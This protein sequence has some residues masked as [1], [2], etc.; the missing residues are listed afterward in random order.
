MRSPSGRGIPKYQLQ[1]KERLAIP[2]IMSWCFYSIFNH[3]LTTQFSSS[4]IPNQSHHTQNHHRNSESNGHHCNSRIFAHNI[5]TSKINNI[6]HLLSIQLFW[7]NSTI[8]PKLELLGKMNFLRGSVS[9]TFSPTNLRTGKFPQ[10]CAWGSRSH[11][12]NCAQVEP[13]PHTASWNTRWAP[14]TEVISGDNKNSRI[15]KRLEVIKWGEVKLEQPYRNWISVG[16]IRELFPL[17]RKKQP[18]QGL[19][20]FQKWWFFPGLPISKFCCKKYLSTSLKTNMDTKIMLWKQVTQ[21]SSIAILGYQFV[22]FRRGLVSPISNS[23]E[24]ST[25]LGHYEAA[26]CA[27]CQTWLQQIHVVETSCWSVGK[28]S[29][30]GFFFTGKTLATKNQKQPAALLWKAKKQHI[31]VKKVYNKPYIT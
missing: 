30:D 2:A 31:L 7:A 16:K 13:S 27:I 24:G 5:Q 19:P 6:S 8:I 23:D 14:V 20:G 11:V 1:S 25:H 28:K 29:T 10:P 26:R 12:M 4:S 22:R 18:L 3:D 9:V 21:L 15:K 17:F